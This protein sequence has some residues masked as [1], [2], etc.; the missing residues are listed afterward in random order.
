MNADFAHNK[1]PQV[2]G[3]QGNTTVYK[4]LNMRIKCYLK[5]HSQAFV[6]TRGQFHKSHFTTNIAIWPIIN[7]IN[8][9][10]AT[11]KVLCENLTFSKTMDLF[12]MG[13]EA[14]PVNG[15]T[16]VQWSTGSSKAARNTPTRAGKK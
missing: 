3:K 16:L 4:Y 13:A 15:L 14:I 8:F 11:L 5:L 10:S 7:I 12:P 2:T 6:A 1:R 9:S